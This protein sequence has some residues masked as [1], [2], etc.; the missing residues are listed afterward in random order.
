MALTEELLKDFDKTQKAPESKRKEAV[1]SMCNDMREG[2]MGKQYSLINE[3]DFEKLVRHGFGESG[4][5]DL[6][7]GGKVAEAAIDVTSATAFPDLL[8]TSLTV[9]MLEFCENAPMTAM[10]LVSQINM[11]CGQTEFYGYHPVGDIVDDE[12]MNEQSETPYKGICPPDKITPPQR[13]KKK[14]AMGI[15]RE[16][17]CYDVNNQIQN[18]MRTGAEIANLHNGKIV[19]RHIFGLNAPGRNANPFIYNDTAYDP[20]YISGG[21]GPW[22]NRMVDNNLDGTITPF[23]A[24]ELF[25]DEQVDPWTGEPTMCNYSDV[26]VASIEARDLAMRGMNTMQLAFDVPAAVLDRVV[27]GGANPRAEGVTVGPKNFGTVTY[28]RYAKRQL[29]DFYEDVVLLDATDAKDAASKTYLVGDLRRAFAWAVEWPFETLERTG[30]D[31]RE[32]FDQEIVWQI[33][34]LWK[35]AP[36]TQTP[37]SV[38]SCVP[39]V[40]AYTSYTTNSSTFTWA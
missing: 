22:E 3:V 36:M 2:Y 34:Y 16:M 29:Q 17:L 5:A 39:D 25:V 19:L 40:T 28:D 27:I 23:E 21:A 30:T 10:N 9:G 37:W 18:L 32:Y 26:L 35:A 12:C 24:I 20:Y 31:T 7:V 13:C 33:K 8:A 6:R 14:F 1:A 15:A 38:L 4:F 11:G